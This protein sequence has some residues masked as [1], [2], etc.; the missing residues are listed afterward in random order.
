MTHEQED[1]SNLFISA[2]NHPT[3]HEDLEIIGATLGFKGGWTKTTRVRLALF[4]ASQMNKR[5]LLNGM[6]AMNERD[7]I[8]CAE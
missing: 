5:E 3:L 8:G 2:A 7:L 6:L 1:V 4:L